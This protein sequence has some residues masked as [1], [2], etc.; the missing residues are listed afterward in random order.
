VDPTGRISRAGSVCSRRA[1]TNGSRIDR[2]P[3]PGFGKPRDTLTSRTHRARGRRWDHVLRDSARADASRR[4]SAQSGAIQCTQAGVRAG[5]AKFGRAGR[6]SGGPGEV[7]AGHT[8]FGSPAPPGATASEAAG[9]RAA[10]HD[11]ERRAWAGCPT[12]GHP[13]AAPQGQ[14]FVPV[15]SEEPLRANA[16]VRSATRLRTACGP[17]SAAVA[18]RGGRRRAAACP[19]R[20]Q[21]PAGPCPSCASR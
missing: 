9:S 20:R 21:P 2:R 8:P 14:L 11:G 10:G 12:F 3:G 5:R 4:D 6:S 18:R 15:A 13:V 16:S 1:R 17:S 19:R 7:R